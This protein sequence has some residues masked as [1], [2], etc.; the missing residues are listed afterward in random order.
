M[1]SFENLR[2]DLLDRVGRTGLAAAGAAN[3]TEA[4]R[5]AG[6]QMARYALRQLKKQTLGWSRG[7]ATIVEAGLQAAN[8]DRTGAAGLLMKAIEQFSQVGM[9]AT[10]AS[11]RLYAASLIGGE[12][13][14]EMDKAAR[15][16]FASQNIVNADRMAAMFV[17]GILPSNP[18]MRN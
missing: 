1:A 2:I 9:R 17:G 14:A 10:E 13:G 8:G 5:K 16:W 15:L 7:K 4:D 11:C 18:A 12:R 3:A 6:L